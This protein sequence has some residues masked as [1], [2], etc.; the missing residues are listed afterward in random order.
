MTKLA[1]LAEIG[2]T[3]EKA[4]LG[5]VA[6]HRSQYIFRRCRCLRGLATLMS[7]LSD[8]GNGPEALQQFLAAA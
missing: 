8:S 7:L 2:E 3:I 4:V 5:Q 6:V 1:D